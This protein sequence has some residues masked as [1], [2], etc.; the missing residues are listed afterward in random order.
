ME[1][2]ASFVLLF[3]FAL[4]FI[5]LRRKAAQRERIRQAYKFDP[6]SPGSARM[7]GYWDLSRGGLFG[8]K[9]V[10]IG[11]HGFH[12]LHYP[13]KGHMTVAA[14]R[15]GKGAT[16][17]VNALLSWIGSV[18]VIDPKAENAAVTGHRRLRFGS[19]YVLNP[20]AMLP[21]TLRGL[22]QARF[23]PMDILDA[24]SLSFHADCDKLA[25]ALVW[26]DGHDPHW[27]TAARILV[28]GVIASLTRH[29]APH[30]R[31]LVAVARVVSGDLFEFCRVTVQATTDPFIA[32]KI[33]RFA[34]APG[35]EA[36]IQAHG[37]CQRRCVCRI[38]A[39]FGG[40]VA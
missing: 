7:A 31:N 4:V 14:A 37:R 40:G 24:A 30:E 6:K 25:A 10:P 34:L 16:L 11:Y 32:Q 1:Q 17:L 28:S 21:C 8:G 15:T 20:F 38:Q 29:G 36:G 27:P 2:W 5:S 18:I 12:A 26:D 35:S 9:G 3:F 19:V 22:K 13:G 33:G 23:N 39:R